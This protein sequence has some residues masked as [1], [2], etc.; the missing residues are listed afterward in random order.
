M[1]GL[2]PGGLCPESASRPG[3]ET[4]WNLTSAVLHEEGLPCLQN[5]MKGGTVRRVIGKHNEIEESGEEGEIHKQVY[6]MDLCYP[7]PIGGPGKKIIRAMVSFL[8]P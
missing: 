4:W 5:G 3:A 8:D 1:E 7:P 6:K 2:L